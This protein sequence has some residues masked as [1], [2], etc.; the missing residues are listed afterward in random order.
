MRSIHQAYVDAGAEVLLTNTFQANPLHLRKH[1][2]LEQGEAICQAGINLARSV[3]PRW[4]IGDIG[5]MTEE[6]GGV[7]FPRPEPLWQ[8]AEWLTGVDALLLETCSDWSVWQAVRWLR[9]KVDIP[10]LLSLTF[11][12][13]DNGTIRA[14]DGHAAADFALV[15]AEHDLAGL[16]VNCGA[17]QDMPRIAEVLRCWR[18]FT[19]VPLFARP[20][21]GTPVQVDGQWRYPLGPEDM[22]AQLPG[23]LSAGVC[24]VGGC[25]GT[26]PAHIAA[27]RRVLP[28]RSAS[29]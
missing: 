27:F 24:M 3:K 28:A 22:A 1:G 26:K 29:K 14:W 4:V 18:Q 6:P 5:P 13:D 12:T 16:G 9:E 17:E 11:R 21:A 10:V 20:N 8:M 23:L 7:N 25:C 15:A 19:E 2:L